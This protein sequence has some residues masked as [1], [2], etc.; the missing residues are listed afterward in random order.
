MSSSTVV[1]PAAPAVAGVAHPE[2][3]VSD[4][5]VPGTA[6]DKETKGKQPP[7]AAQHE[8]KQGE[9]KEKKVKPQANGGAPIEVSVPSFTPCQRRRK[10]REK[11][12]L[13]QLR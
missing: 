6:V 10:G 1:P 11:E 2:Q 3:T 12:N 5:L 8:K 9:K 7:K 4:P 13:V